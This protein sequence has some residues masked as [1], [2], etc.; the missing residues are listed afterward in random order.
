[1]Q[2]VHGKAAYAH[3]FVNSGFLDLAKAFDH[4]DHVIQVNSL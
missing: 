1:M 2:D 3:Q 4:V